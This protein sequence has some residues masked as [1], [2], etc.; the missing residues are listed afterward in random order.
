MAR[1]ALEAPAH[2]E[3]RFL[4]RLVVRLPPAMSDEPPAIARSS[5]INLRNNVPA[6]A[7]L[8]VEK[9]IRRPA[10]IEC[11]S[12]TDLLSLFFQ[13][14]LEQRSVRPKRPFRCSAEPAVHDSSNGAVQNP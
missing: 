5:Q 3:L 1:R 11:R 6:S 7:N 8:S 2:K 14:I 9:Q 13:M 4:F 10:L 12:N